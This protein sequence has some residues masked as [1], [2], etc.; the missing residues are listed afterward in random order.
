M[1]PSKASNYEDD[2]NKIYYTFLVIRTK[3]FHFKEQR[4]LQY[5]FT[6]TT[7]NIK[8]FKLE[9]LVYIGGQEKI[10][11]EYKIILGG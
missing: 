6:E 10:H 2:K 3:R 5:N 7:I 8:L 11:Q 1:A 4:I 9:V